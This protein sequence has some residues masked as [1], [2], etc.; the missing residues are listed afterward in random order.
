MK[1]NAVKKFLNLCQ[2]IMFLK[3]TRTTDR[4]DCFIEHTFR[5]NISIVTK[6][7]T[8]CSINLT[9]IKI[10]INVSHIQFNIKFR[11]SLPE[12]VETRS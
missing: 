9:I 3:K 8:N 12:P 4:G 6:A 11:I 7:V 10:H 5:R 1:K 2:N